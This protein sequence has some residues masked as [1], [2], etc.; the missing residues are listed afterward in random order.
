[1][2]KQSK[3]EFCGLG[4]ESY[5][6]PCKCSE[7]GSHRPHLVGEKAYIVHGPDGYQYRFS[8]LPRNPKFVVVRVVEFGADGRPH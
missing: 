5:A 1:M 2:E 3:C 8:N 6:S 4:S 7:S